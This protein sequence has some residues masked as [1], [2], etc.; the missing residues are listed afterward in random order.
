MCFLFVIQ[1]MHS[2]EVLK[3]TCDYV[4]ENTVKLR[5][6]RYVEALSNTL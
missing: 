4:F 2:I 6:M 3:L 1:P 5:N